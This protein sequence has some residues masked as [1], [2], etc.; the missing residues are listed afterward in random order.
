MSR[1]RCGRVPPMPTRGQLVPTGRCSNGRMGTG[2]WRSS[3]VLP[4]R[5]RCKRSALYLQLVYSWCGTRSTDERWIGRPGRW[6]NAVRKIGLAVW[7]NQRGISS[8]TSGGELIA[9]VEKD[10]GTSGEQ[11]LIRHMVSFR[12]KHTYRPVAPVETTWS[13]SPP[14][15]RL[16]NDIRVP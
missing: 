9:E 7:V 2:L 14:D 8:I 16:T 5:G 1:E 15:F 3:G 6:S 10:K 4:P 13:G 11:L 12:Q